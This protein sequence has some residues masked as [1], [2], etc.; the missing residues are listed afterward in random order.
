M[1]GRPSQDDALRGLIRAFEVRL[2]ESV[3]L[4]THHRADE[5]AAHQATVV[6][7]LQEVLAELPSEPEPEPG[8]LRDVLS[9]LLRSGVLPVFAVLLVLVFA[10]PRSTTVL[11]LFFVAVPLALVIR[12]MLEAYRAAELDRHGARLQERSEQFGRARRQLDAL[13]V[14]VDAAQAERPPGTHLVVQKVADF[15]SNVVAVRDGLADVANRLHRGTRRAQA[16]VAEWPDDPALAFT[17]SPDGLGPLEPRSM[18][19]ALRDLVARLA[20]LSPMAADAALAAGMGTGDSAPFGRVKPR[21]VAQD[22]EDIHRDVSQARGPIVGE[23]RRLWRSFD[24]VHRSASRELLRARIRRV[25]VRSA[26]LAVV[27]APSLTIRSPQT[28]TRQRSVYLASVNTQEEP[29]L[30][31]IGRAAGLML[32]AA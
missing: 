12:W 3:D 4:S 15:R 17:F 31:G 27:S 18:D 1:T 23:C 11:V 6:A 22:L 13:L 28:R 10:L 25:T 29:T 32:R 26:A 9:G 19:A 21:A 20:R 8:R 2:G 5:I 14:A 16:F 7:R 30:G 24:T